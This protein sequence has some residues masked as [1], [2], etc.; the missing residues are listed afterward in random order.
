[1]L[2]FFRRIRRKLSDENSFIRYSR[3][4]IGEILLVVIGILIALQVNNWNEDKKL[5]KSEIKIL[6]ELKRSISRDL[7][8]LNVNIEF[9]QRKLRYF[10]TI[11]REISQDKPNRDSLTTE[12]AL[13][14]QTHFFDEEVGPYEVLKSKGL[15]LVSNDTIREQIVTLYEKNYVFVEKNQKNKFIDE[16]YVQEYYSKLFDNIAYADSITDIHYY[17]EIKPHDLKS[18]KSDKLFNTIF[19]TK[20][21]QTEYLINFIFG[22]TMKKVEVVLSNLEKEIDRLEN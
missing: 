10:K 14:F 17:R 16:R 13:V 7:K 3:Y 21:A 22:V 9:E 2:N 20:I 12:F 19:N 1:M 8:M 6:K 18:L 5:K 15:T 11:K 4:A